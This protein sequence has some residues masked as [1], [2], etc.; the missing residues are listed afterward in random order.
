LPKS[1]IFL[2]ESKNNKESIYGILTWLEKLG[3]G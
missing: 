1:R 2:I 3:R